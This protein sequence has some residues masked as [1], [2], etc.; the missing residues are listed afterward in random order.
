[1]KRC[2]GW[3]GAAVGDEQVAI[4][5]QDGAAPDEAEREE[6]FAAAKR[7]QQNIHKIEDGSR[8]VAQKT[9]ELLRSTTE[10]EAKISREVRTHVSACSAPC[11]S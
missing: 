7:V 8:A 10:A 3:Q 5:I 2:V 6:F 1:M 11:S 4:D 9:E